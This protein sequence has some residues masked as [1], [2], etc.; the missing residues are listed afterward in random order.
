VI[1]GFIVLVGIHKATA[2]GQCN[3]QILLFGIRPK[4][5][6]RQAISEKYRQAL[7]HRSTCG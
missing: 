1:S 5:D 6:I 4:L 7:Q 2:I 3:N